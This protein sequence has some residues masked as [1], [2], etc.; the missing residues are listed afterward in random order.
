MN[1]LIYHAKWWLTEDELSPRDT[2]IRLNDIPFSPFKYR[3]PREVFT[4]LLGD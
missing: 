3:K 4:G 2:A 1:D